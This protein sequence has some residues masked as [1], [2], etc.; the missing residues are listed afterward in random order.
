MPKAGRDDNHCW[1]GA[2]SINSLTQH[3]PCRGVVPLTN[4]S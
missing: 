4:V 2:N 1:D 3:F